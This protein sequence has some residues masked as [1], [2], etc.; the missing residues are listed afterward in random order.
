M[1]VLSRCPGPAKVYSDACAAIDWTMPVLAG[2]FTPLLLQ[3]RLLMDIEAHRKL[4]KPTD[5]TNAETCRNV[6]AM[7]R[8]SDQ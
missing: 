1:L 7:P 3:D 4:S 2:I 8:V 5:A 6:L